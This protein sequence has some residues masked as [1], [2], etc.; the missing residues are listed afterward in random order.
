[1]LESIINNMDNREG[2]KLIENGEYDK[3]MGFFKSR[4]DSDDPTVYYGLATAIFKKS[5]SSLKKEETKKVIELYERSIENS[6]FGDAYLM[7][8]MAYEKMASI[9]INEYKKDPYIDSD[10]KVKEIK[11]FL[12][13]A[14]I[15]IEKS[16]E[17]NPF[18]KDIAQSEL[19]SYRKRL[20]NIDNLKKYYDETMV[21]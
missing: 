11:D 2:I 8:G 5:S 7:L 9:L 6:E 3:A 21:K 17:F 12:L 16:V 15:V 18:F 4:L 13:L 14:K 10:N 1:M 20:N 19:S